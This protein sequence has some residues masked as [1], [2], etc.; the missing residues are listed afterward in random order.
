MTNILSMILFVI[1][2][3]LF[4]FKLSTAIDTITQFQS[5]DDGNT[6]VSND[7]TFEL[8]F[9][10]PGSSTNRYVGIW[11][12]NI[13]KRRIVWVANRDNPIK[14]NNSNSTM[15][16]I[17]NE[18]NLVLLSNN[19]QTLVWSTNITTRSLS[20]T[21]SHVAQLLDNGNFVIKANN[22]T[23]QQ[24][25]NFLWQ[26]FDFPCDTLLPDMK[27]GWDLKIGLN[28]PL[29]SWKNWDDPSSG[30]LTWGIVLRS[31]PEI[32][33][34]RGSVEIHR[35][36][37]WNGV[38]FSGAPMEIVTSTVVVARSVN[39]SNEV[40]YS[41]SLVNK[42]NVSITYLNQT[43][44]LHERIIWSPEDNTWSGIESVPKDDCDVYNHCGPYGNCI[45]NPSPICQCLDGFEPKSPQNWDA[46][47]WT[48]G[49]VRKG[50]ETWNCGVN[51]GFGTF[52]GLKLPDTTHTWVDANMTLENCKNKCLENCSCMAYSNLDVAG[53]GSGCS[54]WFG[55][56][57]DLKQILTFQQYLYIR[58]DASTVDSSGDVSGGKKNHTLAIAVTIPLVV[59]L[60]LVIIVFYVYMRKRKQREINTLTEEKDEDQQDF[61]LPFFNISTM[62]SA[63]NDFSNYNK[64]GEG[65]FGP[66]Y[67]GTLAT[68]GQEIAVK[69]LSGSSKQGTREF[70]NEVILCAKLQH[71]NLVKVLGCCIQGEE[72]MLIY[73]YMPNKSLDSFLFDSAQKKLLDWYKRFNIICGVARGLIYLHQ[74]SRL[75]II[76]RDL[77][78]S[79][80][81]LDNDMNAKISDFGLAK[82]CGD[83]QVEGNTKRVVGTH[84]YMA[85]EYAIDGLF[86]TKSDVFSF[87]VLLLE[88]VSG[89]KNKGLTFPSNNHNLVGH[90][91]RLWKEGNSEELIDD[92]LK[93][94]YIPSEALRSIQVGLLCLQLHPNDRPNMTY[95]LAML[96]NESVLAQPK[97]P[98]FII[99]R[100]FDEGESTTKPF[101]INE[102]TISLIDAR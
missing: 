40:Y 70:K 12:K 39:N 67:K 8:G 53:D 45:Y 71:R 89:Q 75:R 30:D 51:D 54:I 2:N 7:G 23:D 80:I 63:T 20:T 37:P 64:L 35:S 19:N 34:K 25:N 55:D 93:D 6:L 59:I 78:P 49:C 43:L 57:I 62:I 102:V 87:G 42:S 47:N 69:R 14:D 60:L 4:F 15:L 74:D 61:E 29:T 17:S 24:S 9:F 83:D 41:Y 33:L 21:S 77:K 84:G 73:E 91:W 72:R 65:G 94:S 26:G 66:V 50:E 46:S 68:D 101:S 13:P 95:V 92:C 31:N 56:L 38:G 85:P 81:L 27:L 10:T 79:N 76:H 98:G 1:L 32:V 16:I 88:I 36:G 82:I 5:L 28:R 90:A 52:S 3:L 86:S 97:E 11:Y 18:G 44:S 58:M 100:V 22:N 48:Q 96:T 99:Q